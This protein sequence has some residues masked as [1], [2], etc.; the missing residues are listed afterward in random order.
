VGAGIA[1]EMIFSGLPWT[2]EEAFRVGL[3][4]RVAPAA[5]L[6][7]ECEKIATVY[8]ERAAYALKTAKQLINRGVEL[9]LKDGLALERKMIAEMAT[10]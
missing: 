7:K 8:I 6:I 4:N 2:A 5:E 3:V 10:P 1:K 9:P